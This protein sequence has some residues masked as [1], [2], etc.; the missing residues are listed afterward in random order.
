[1][2]FIPRAMALQL[3]VS[4]RER[5]DQAENEPKFSPAIDLALLPYN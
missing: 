1:M 3:V 2:L 4:G 5:P